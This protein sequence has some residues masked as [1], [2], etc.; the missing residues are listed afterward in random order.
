LIVGASNCATFAGIMQGLNGRQFVLFNSIK[1]NSTLGL[2]LDLLTASAVRRVVKASD[3]KFGF[4]D[5]GS[6]E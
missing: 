3:K 1:S 6:D 5:E 2:P 4:R